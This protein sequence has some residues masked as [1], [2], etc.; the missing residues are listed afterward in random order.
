MAMMETPELL[1]KYREET[2]V[3]I[4]RNANSINWKFYCEFNVSRMRG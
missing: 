1:K 2:T 4:K 3:P